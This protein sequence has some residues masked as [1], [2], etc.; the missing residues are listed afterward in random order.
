MRRRELI[1]LASGATAVM[2]L[3]ARAQQPAMPVIGYL[4]SASTDRVTHFAGA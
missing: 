2:P 3:G 1:A 4:S